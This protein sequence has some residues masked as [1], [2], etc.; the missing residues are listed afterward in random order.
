MKTGA[1]EVRKSF[2]RIFNEFQRIYS[3]ALLFRFTNIDNA[4]LRIFI[5]YDDRSIIKYITGKGGGGK[6]ILLSF[7]FNYHVSWCIIILLIFVERIGLP[8]CVCVCARV[9]F[10]Q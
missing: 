1:E 5:S 3:R 10:P 8:M 4:L 7:Y 2:Y 6:K 9:F